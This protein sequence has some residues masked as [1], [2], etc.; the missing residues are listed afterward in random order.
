MLLG[1]PA[2]GLRAFF[3]QSSA[4]AKQPG[5]GQDETG[6]NSVDR[7]GAW[8]TNVTPRRHVL[9]DRQGPL[10]RSMTPVFGHEIAR[11]SASFSCSPSASRVESPRRTNSRRSWEVLIHVG[12]SAQPPRSHD[13]TATIGRR[14]YGLFG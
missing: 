4:L 14:Q 7:F 6:S 12:D 9:V 3:G 1:P 2:R 13:R 10:E 8:I 5:Q 11:Y